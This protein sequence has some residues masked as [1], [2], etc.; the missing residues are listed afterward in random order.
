MKLL[1]HACDLLEKDWLAAML[2]DVIDDEIVDLE[3]KCYV[4][5]SIHVVSS[6]GHPLSHYEDYFKNCRQRFKNIVLVH[7]SDEWFSG[8]YSLYRYFDAVVRNFHTYLA[9]GHGILTI[10]EGYSNGTATNGNSKPADQRRYAWSFIGELK[11]SRIKMVQCMKGFEPK[12]LIQT[13]SISD[14]NGKK[15]SKSEFDSVLRNSVFSPCPMGNVILETWRF[16]ESLELGC[17]PLAECRRS[18]DYF[19]NL[20]GPHPIPTFR[21]WQDARR[22]AETLFADKRQLLAKQEEISSWWGLYKEEVRSDLQTHITGPSR[23]EELINYANLLRN[24]VSILHEPLRLA[25]LLRHQSAAS[26]RR[27]LS[28][29]VGPLQRIIGETF[30]LSG[31]RPNSGRL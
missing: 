10:P 27:R 1:W 11:A 28:K 13:S 7:L 20:L 18:L 23:S 4:E 25:E 8:T 16:Y 24:R 6:N 22:Y 26:L 15:L 19:R 2:G 31:H 29:P 17:I 21:T 30:K 3:L 14:P 12:L 5:D 9:D